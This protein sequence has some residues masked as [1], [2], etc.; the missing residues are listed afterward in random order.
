MF[1]MNVNTFQQIDTVLHEQI[2][3]V[4]YTVVQSFESLYAMLES[5]RVSTTCKYDA[6]V[7]KW[8]AEIAALKEEWENLKANR[9][10]TETLKL[11]PPPVLE[12]GNISIQIREL[13]QALNS[14]I[15]L[16]YELLSLYSTYKR[17][18]ST[19]YDAEESS[20]TMLFRFT[21]ALLHIE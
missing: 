3:F 11:P 13:A 6:V 20:A 21:P 16:H 5:E 1:Q 18:H 12:D 17:I 9:V 15:S 4:Q 7:S 8:R 10:P 14:A 19:L 2:Q